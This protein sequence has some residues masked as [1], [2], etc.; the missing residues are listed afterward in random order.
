[1]KLKVTD[2]DGRNHE[3]EAAPGA[4]L[5]D[6]ILGSDLEIAAQCGGCCSCATCHVYVAEEWRSRLAEPDEEE[7][8]ML[9]LAME[10]T[11]RSRLSCQLRLTDDL[12]GLAVTLAPGSRI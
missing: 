6:A 7:V 5:L 8:A 9:E 10:P 4:C 2:Q 1:M 3:I 12:D 11:D